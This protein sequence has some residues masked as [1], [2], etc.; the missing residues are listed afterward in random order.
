MHIC[1]S[2][3][4]SKNKLHKCYCRNAI[5]PSYNYAHDI[6]KTEGFFIAKGVSQVE[7]ATYRQGPRSKFLSG[8]GGG[9]GAKEERVDE[10]F[11]GGEEHAGEFLSNFSKI[12]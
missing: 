6:L 12:D 10:L 11:L 5:A 7:D 1:K 4:G 2:S 8:V 3:L 9:G